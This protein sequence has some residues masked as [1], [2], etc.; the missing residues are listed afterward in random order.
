MGIS[1]TD[2]ALLSPE[3]EAEVASDLSQDL[4]LAMRRIA[5]QAERAGRVIKSVHDFVRRR[6]RVRECVAPQDLVDAIMRFADLRKQ[7]S[8]LAAGG[9]V[10]QHFTSARP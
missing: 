10:P 5:E 2:P 3:A 4:Q 9:G 8:R 1:S 6:D 7:R